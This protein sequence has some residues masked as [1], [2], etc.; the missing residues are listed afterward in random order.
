MLKTDTPISFLGGVDKNT[1]IIIDKSHPLCGECIAGKILVFPYGKGS[2]VGSYVLYA[3]SRKNLAPAGIVN[4]ECETIIA[5]GAIIS[6]I[7][8]I[9]RLDG[10]IPDGVKA[11]V[12]GDCGTVSYE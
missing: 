1:G 7:P 10:D 2:T 8:A 6:E 11:E 4:T 5:I 9:D 3:L 12:D